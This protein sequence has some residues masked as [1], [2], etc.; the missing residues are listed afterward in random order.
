MIWPVSET[1][2]KLEAWPKAWLL[3][4]FGG[5]LETVVPIGA[6]KSLSSAVKDVDDRLFR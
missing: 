4:Y 2:P 6:T 1:W 5:Q 3:R